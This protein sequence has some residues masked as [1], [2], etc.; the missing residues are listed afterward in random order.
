MRARVP[1]R[2]R[3]RIPE[4]ET[5]RRSWFFPWIGLKPFDQQPKLRQIGLTELGV[6]SQVS[7]KR[8]QRSAK[9]SMHEIPN[10]PAKHVPLGVPRLILIDAVNPA[11]LELPLD[12]QAAHDVERGG[13]N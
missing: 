11:A 8:R 10:Q 13:A 2:A 7:D 3:T 12:D 9:C 5:G 1:R 4:S 6:F